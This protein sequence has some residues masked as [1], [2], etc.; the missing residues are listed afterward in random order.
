MKH[1]LLRRIAY[2]FKSQMSS[3]YEPPVAIAYTPRW[4]FEEATEA[5]R[6]QMSDGKQEVW[7][8]KSG[9]IIAIRRVAD[10]P[11]AYG[12]CPCHCHTT[13]GVSHCVPCCKPERND[14]ACADESPNAQRA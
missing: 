2:L 1:W 9:E 8:N 4:V 7:R 6:K 3:K 11:P 10:C 14:E 12:N 5:Y 13:P